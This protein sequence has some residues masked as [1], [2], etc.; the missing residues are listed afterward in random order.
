MN[1]KSLWTNPDRPFPIVSTA[2]KMVKHF[3]IFYFKLNWLRLQNLFFFMLN[4][5]QDK[6]LVSSSNNSKHD[7]KKPQNTHKWKL[8]FKWKLRLIKKTIWTK[9]DL[10][11]NYVHFWEKNIISNLSSRFSYQ[12]QAKCIYIC[13]IFS[14]RDIYNIY[15]KC[16]IWFSYIIYRK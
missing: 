13:V 4:S 10:L 2:S 12:I 6:I 16:S 14:E 9:S 15:N 7:V 3:F 11:I 1:S 5:I 8:F